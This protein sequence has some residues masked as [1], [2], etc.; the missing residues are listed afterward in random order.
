LKTT[1]LTRNPTRAAELSALGAATIVADLAT[2]GWHGQLAGGAD[3]SVACTL[4][5][6]RRVG[7]FLASLDKE[8][9]AR[10]IVVVLSEHGEM[11]AKHGRFGRAGGIRGTLFDDVVHIPLLVR[12]P[13]V[14]GRRVHGLVQLEDVMPTLLSLLAVPAR[15]KG[16]G[17]SLLPLISTGT[18]VNDY[19][20][21]GTKY[22]T[23]M[24]ETYGP[25]GFS[26]INE[27]IRNY[28]WKLIHELTFPDPKEGRSAKKPEE[29]FELYNIAEDPG[30]TLNV[31]AQNPGVVNDLARKLRE[32]VESSRKFSRN[33]T[34]V[35]EL[36]KDVLENAKHRESFR[37]FEIGLEIHK[38]E[39][40]ASA[41][42][43][44][45]NGR[46]WSGPW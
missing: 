21:G 26:S 29:T 46:R 40:R 7:K 5:E 32:W 42:G 43:F 3:L 30:E 15:A 10:T 33:G 27:Y 37:L 8:L 16:Q 20:Y 18:P 45:W 13:G 19:V 23:Y 24:P 11:F 34:S 4:D 39:P 9:L 22:N 36:P 28:D 38:T 6:D 35:R 31:A 17:S 12:L 1:A 25:Y 44:T 2:D 41:S 14:Q